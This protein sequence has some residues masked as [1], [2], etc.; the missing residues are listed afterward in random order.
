MTNCA[1]KVSDFLYIVPTIPHLR[2]VKISIDYRE[3]PEEESALTTFNSPTKWKQDPDAS[4]RGPF[5]PRYKYYVNGQLIGE[6]MPKSYTPS[7]DPFPEHR[8]PR[9]GG[10]VAVSPDE[11][12]YARLCIE[13]GLGDLLTEQQK[14]SVLNGAHLTPRSMASNE[15]TDYVNAELSPTSKSPNIPQVNGIKHSQEPLTLSIA[16]DAGK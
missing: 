16:E 5:A 11:P 7:K 2:N 1:I 4:I 15:H 8:V 3:L 12:D 13:Q 6:D 10:L 9:R 14:Q